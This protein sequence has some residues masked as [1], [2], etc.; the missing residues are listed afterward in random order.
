MRLHA[1]CPS[2]GRRGRSGFSLLELLLVLGLAAWLATLAVPFLGGVL[3]GRQLQSAAES[4]VADLRLARSEAIQRQ[5]IV[6]VCSSSDGASCTSAAAWVQGWLVFVD[7]DGNRRRDA[8][9]PVLRVQQRLPGLASIASAAPL[10]DKAIFS[11]QPSGW[12]KAASQSLLFTAEGGPAPARLVCISSQGR[13]AL[14]PPGQTA[15]S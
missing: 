5:A 12:A 2:A 6:A 3:M 14:R 15:C 8:G 11:Y 7:R 4:L 1:M 13:P 9:E 10:N